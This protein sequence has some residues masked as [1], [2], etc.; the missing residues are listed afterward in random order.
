MASKEIL[1]NRIIAARCRFFFKWANWN[2]MT[3]PIVE[4]V[5]LSLRV[6]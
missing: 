2:F 4:D 5:A 1:I 6:G 3:K